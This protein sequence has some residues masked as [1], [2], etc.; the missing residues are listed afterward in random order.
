MKRLRRLGLPDWAFN[1]VAGEHGDEVAR[2]VAAAEDVRQAQAAAIEGRDGPDVRTTLHEL[3]ERTSRLVAL[4]RAAVERSAHT[5]T[6]ASTGELTARLAEIAGN[7][8]EADHLAAGLLG[9]EDPGVA[10]L[11]A[12]L[13]PSRRP[14]RRKAAAKPTA[15]AS[16]PPA[17]TRSAKEEAVERRARV[18]ELATAERQQVAAAKTVAAADAAVG[19]AEAELAA[20]QERLAAATAAKQEAADALTAADAAVAEARAAVNP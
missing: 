18:R 3:R 7:P 16:P 14:S 11:F 20:A 17:P 12:G 10:D 9:A 5:S 6:T 2:F 15:A 1:V 19:K 8:A 13:V 4:A